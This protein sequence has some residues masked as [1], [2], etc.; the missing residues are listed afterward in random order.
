[1]VFRMTGGRAD[2]KPIMIIVQALR[3]KITMNS[4]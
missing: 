2:K 1:M 4:G 3:P